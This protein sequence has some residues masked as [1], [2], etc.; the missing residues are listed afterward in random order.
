VQGIKGLNPD[1]KAYKTPPFMGDSSHLANYV[2]LTGDQVPGLSGAM[3]SNGYGV[4]GVVFA[5]F[6]SNTSKR[7]AVATQISDVQACITRLGSQGRLQLIS[8]CEGFTSKAPP[9]IGS[10]LSTIAVCE[11]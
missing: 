9:I 1:K 5:L 10:A 3:V 11:L 8:K 6:S 2:L 4:A 7:I